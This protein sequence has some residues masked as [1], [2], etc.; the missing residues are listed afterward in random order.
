MPK[1]HLSIVV[2]VYNRLDLMQPV[3]AA[4]AS[5]QTTASF[6][7]IVVDDGSDP[8]VAQVMAGR[9]DRFRLLKQANRGRS[10]AINA[11]LASSNG[12]IVIVCDADIVP[13]IRFVE[14]H[15]AFHREHPAPEDTHLGVVTWG[16][17]PSPFAALLGPRAN[18]RMV[19]LE[20]HMPWN[21]WYTDNWSFKRRLIDSGVLRFDETFH[22]WGWEDL[23][24]GSRLA[25]QGIRNSATE[26][27][28]G[29]HLQSP[30]LE[31]MLEKFASSIPN[32]LHLAGR[33]EHDDSVRSWLAH[34]Y[35]SLLLV[36]AGENILRRSI[37]HVEAVADRLPGLDQTIL[38]NLSTSVSDAVFRCGMQ[39]GF[40][41][42]QGDSNALS[43]GD[44]ARAAMLPHADL[45]RITIAVLITTEQTDAARMFLDSIARRVADTGGDQE[46]VTQ[47][48]ARA[49]AF[50]SPP[51]ADPYRS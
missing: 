37:A 48:I 24:I 50:R 5:Q 28:E 18:P 38:R 2:P 42:S 7:V 3:L 41:E 29:R 22:G 21:L 44:M 39:R 36:E 15:L 9:D 23:E 45:V 26:A 35:T 11:G 17:Q 32:L 33:V 8:P 40:V 6:E 25:A 43:A 4:F 19:G 34:R 14:E 46:L 31:G 47:F 13:S 49:T 30:T 1:P 27:A 12:E 51:S 10:A 20:G 16:L